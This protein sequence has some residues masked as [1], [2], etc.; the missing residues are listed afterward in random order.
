MS[1]T[2]QMKE[3]L[4]IGRDS[5]TGGQT[6]RGTEGWRG[7][8]MEGQWDGKR[9][10]DSTKEREKDRDRFGEKWCEKEVGIIKETRRQ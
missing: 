6:E 7:R 10:R 2:R 9:V 8:R 1:L 5:G 4:V 3:R